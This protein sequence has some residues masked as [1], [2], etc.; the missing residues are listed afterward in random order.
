MRVYQINYDLRNQRN[1]Q[2]LHE[3]IQTYEDWAHP[4]RSCWIIATSKGA[5]EVRNHL[6]AVMDGDDGLL[7]TRLSG[8]AAWRVLDH[9]R[10][11]QMTNWL[12][13]RLQQA[14]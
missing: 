4:L 9:D 8:E 10:D 1:Y 7:V 11:G 12:K 3:A 2:D 5:T 13:G 6:A 14:A